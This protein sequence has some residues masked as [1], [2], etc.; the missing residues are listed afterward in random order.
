LLFVA[1]GDTREAIGSLSAAFAEK[2]PDLPWMAVDPRFDL[3]RSSASF[4]EMVSQ[5]KLR[6]NP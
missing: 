4:R 2:E 3:I 1:L 6:L 5:M